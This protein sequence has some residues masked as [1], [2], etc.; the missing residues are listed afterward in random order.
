MGS[1]DDSRR[2]RD[3]ALEAGFDRAG[4]VR[5]GPALTLSLIHI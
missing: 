1:A 3:L 2:I 5:L 4:I